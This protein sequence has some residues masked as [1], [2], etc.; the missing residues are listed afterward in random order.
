MRRGNP[1]ATLQ[2]REGECG[3]TRLFRMVVVLAVRDP[4]A[5]RWIRSKD[6]ELV[7]A[8]ANLE[9][10]AVQRAIE[11]GHVPKTYRNRKSGNA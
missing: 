6:G 1:P 8:L 5:A 9:R 11:G 3:I 4:D 10:A 2:E 7:C